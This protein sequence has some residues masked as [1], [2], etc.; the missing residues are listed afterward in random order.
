LKLV[1]QLQLLPSWSQGPQIP[2]FESRTRYEENNLNPEANIVGGDIV[3]SFRSPTE[4]FT[5]CR[6]PIIA[7]GNGPI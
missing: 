1:V 2:S 3:L 7:F 6:K 4:L 5:T